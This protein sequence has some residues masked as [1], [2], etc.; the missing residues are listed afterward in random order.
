M[1]GPV[2]TVLL[3]A[4]KQMGDGPGKCPPSMAGAEVMGFLAGRASATVSNG[5][6]QVE[7]D[8]R[9]ALKIGR[10]THEVVRAILTLSS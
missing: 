6:G 1:G 8:R 9:R 4:E 2:G 5:Q 3:L 10:C 7:D